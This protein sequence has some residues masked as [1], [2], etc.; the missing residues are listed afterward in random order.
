MAHVELF[1]DGRVVL[2]SP[3]IGIEGAERDGAVVVDGRCA[4]PVRTLDPTG[5]LFLDRHGPHPRQRVPLWGR[6]LAPDGLL[7]RERP[8]RGVRGRPPV[9]RRRSHDPAAGQGPDRGGGRTPRPPACGYTFPRRIESASAGARSRAGR[10]PRRDGL[11]LVGR[12]E[13]AVGHDRSAKTYKLVGFSREPI[14]PGKPVKVSFRIQLPSG[15][16]L[17]AYNRGAG[18]H[19]GVHLIAVR[20]DLSLLIHHTPRSAPTGCSRPR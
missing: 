15:K 17:T 5:V 2:L 4:Y 8:G 9:R 18:P 12:E 19:T 3:G 1:V 13:R 6:R 16:T 7:G 11:R 20:D 10:G 14:D